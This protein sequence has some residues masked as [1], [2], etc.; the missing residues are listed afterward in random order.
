MTNHFFS[1]GDFFSA[2]SLVDTF[3]VATFFVGAFIGGSS[4]KPSPI[5]QREVDRI[6]ARV[7][8]L[9]LSFKSLCLFAE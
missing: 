9:C 2:T 8:T 6:F 7:Q 3:L 1:A 4:G 5:S